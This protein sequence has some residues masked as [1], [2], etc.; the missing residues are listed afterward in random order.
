MMNLKFEKLM[1]NDSVD[2]SSYEEALEFAITITKLL[3]SNIFQC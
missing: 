3:M 2:I 1:P